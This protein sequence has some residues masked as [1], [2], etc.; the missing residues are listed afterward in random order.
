MNS[1]SV[2][3]VV[4]PIWACSTPAS[5]R[6]TNRAASTNPST[7]ITLPARTISRSGLYEKLKM[8]FSA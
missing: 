1:T 7:Q 5:R 4:N 8:P 2:T 6:M 3:S